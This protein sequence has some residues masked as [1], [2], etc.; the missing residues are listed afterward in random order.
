MAFS[1]SIAGKVYNVLLERNDRV[2][3]TKNIKSA[4]ELLK[5][6]FTAVLV[7]LTRAEV[8][9]PV[10]FKGVYYVR[11]REEKDLKTIKEDPLEVVARACNLKLKADWYYGLATA[12]KLSGVWE[13]QSHVTITV[14]S[15]K[16][17]NRATSFAGMTIKF[18]QLS[19][20][21][22][23]K[24]VRKKGV[25]RYSDPSRTLLDYAYFGARNKESVDYAKT[26]LSELAKTKG[27][28]EKLLKNA[29]TLV[30]KYPGLYAVFLRK[31]FGLD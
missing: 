29:S 22:F 11:N 4:C 30:N 10:I 6:D 26:V 20:V 17:V 21:P 19:G 24:H 7:G 8:L 28:E 9:E 31:F 25:M 12:L 5:I 14:I 1:D 15:K 23:N 16:R 2:I 3:E 13:Q 27:G 18:K